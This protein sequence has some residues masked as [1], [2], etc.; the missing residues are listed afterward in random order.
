M[1]FPAALMIAGTS[2]QMY[3]QFTEAGA[4]ADAER[5]NAQWLLEQEKYAREAMERSIQ[6]ANFEYTNKLGTQAS[7]YAR[8]GV[9][10][11]GSAAMTMGGTIKQ[12]LSEVF[13]LRRKGEMDMRL[14]RIKANE[15]SSRAEMLS[16]PQY[17]L[18]QGGSTFL[19]NYRTS[20]GF[21]QGFPSWMNGGTPPSAR[22][23][24]PQYFPE[25]QPSTAFD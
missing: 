7:G 2:M 16:S 1:A 23:A 6:L 17:M 15:S 4:M 10:I 22:G 14:A 24:E 9:A 25:L 19:N 18:M 3:G 11:S 13:A 5:K 20:E 12:A 8:G 21:G